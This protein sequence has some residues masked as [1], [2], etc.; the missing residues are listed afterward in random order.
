VGEVIESET[1]VALS[2]QTGKRVPVRLLAI[3]TVIL[4]A[5]ACDRTRSAA[6]GSGPATVPAP[7]AALVPASAPVYRPE[8]FRQDVS[9]LIGSD[10]FDL[11]AALVRSADVDRQV[12]YDGSG[13]MAVGG[14]SVFLPAVDPKLMY[15]PDRDWYLPRTSDVITERDADWQKAAGEFA[16]RYNQRRTSKGR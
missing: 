12:E 10:Q 4:L 13:Y 2:R 11:A 5:P 3:L 14:Y 9:T 1:I 6:G 15:E 8:S 7:G 16:Y